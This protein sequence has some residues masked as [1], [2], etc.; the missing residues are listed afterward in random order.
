[1]ANA[2]FEEAYRSVHTQWFCWY[3][4]QSWD[5]DTPFC[6]L[7]ASQDVSTVDWSNQSLP[8]AQMSDHS[9]SMKARWSLWQETCNPHE[10]ADYLSCSRKPHDYT[11]SMKVLFRETEWNCCYGE[12]RLH[13][14]FDAL[15]SHCFLRLSL[16]GLVLGCPHLTPHASRLE[17]SQF[18]S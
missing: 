9:R 10:L 2:P 1:M 8:Q 13:L 18:G 12:A 17:H 4:E 3:Q 5:L 15:S 14:N 11:L 16:A 7:S 6:F